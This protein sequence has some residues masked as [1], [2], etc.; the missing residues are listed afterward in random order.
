MSFVTGPT[1]RGGADAAWK[2]PSLTID[3]KTT[4]HSPHFARG[5]MAAPASGTGFS[6]QIPRPSAAI[7]FDELSQIGE[8]LSPAVRRSPRFAP[9]QSAGLGL[10][11]A[12]SYRGSTLSTSS[13]SPESPDAPVITTD[14]AVA[15]LEAALAFPRE[16]MMVRA[17]SELQR[18]EKAAATAPTPKPKLGRPKKAAGRGGRG[19]AQ[20]KPDAAPAPI[21]PEVAAALAA[22]TGDDG[23]GKRRRRRGGRDEPYVCPYAE[24][25]KVYKKSSHLKAHIRRHTGEKPFKCSQCSWKF[26][27]SDELSR[28]E[29][30]HTGEKPFKC[31]K[32]DKSFA[33]SDHLNKHIT[34]HKD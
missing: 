31:T 12:P 8:M 2:K 11:G 4:T 18:R 10:G 29:R 14:M 22:A 3:T 28:H 25:G 13:S 7:V 17:A 21:P 6:G 15:E 34:I 33:R 20:R 27:R 24:C 19:G 5:V 26:S 9:G 23:S 30:L 1:T 32:C 16:A